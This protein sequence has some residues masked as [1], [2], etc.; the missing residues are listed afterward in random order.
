MSAADDA[1]LIA[2]VRR[3]DPRA[4]E[5]LV[6]RYLDR[7]A[8]VA[9]RLLRDRHEALDVA[10]EVFLL[11]HGALRTWRD[12]GLL[13]SWLYR[14]TLNVC[15]HRLRTR[16][17]MIPVDVPPDRPQPPPPPDQT[18]RLEA[19][20]QAVEGLPGRQRDVFVLRHEEGLPLAAIARRLGLS[21]GTVKAH[22]HRALTALRDALK[23]R[24]ML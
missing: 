16:R 19:L 20:R 8:G 14:T 4:F 22:L 1:D 2:R 13:F 18:D 12:E 7:V 10:Q 21:E 3:G 23:T 11:L 15:S 5:A 24:G 9:S 6:D 17:R